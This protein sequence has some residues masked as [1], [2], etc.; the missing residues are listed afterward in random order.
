MT[1]DELIK[2]VDE[3][4]L[5]AID[6]FQSSLSKI[7]EDIFS[8]VVSEITQL[9]TSQGNITV[10]IENL[11]KIDRI[12]S[13]INE[14]VLN[15]DYIN[16]V[17]EFAKTFNDVQGILNTYFSS[18]SAEFGVKSVY[19]AVRVANIQTTIESLVGAGI[20]QGLTNPIKN[21][22]ND[23]VVN[24][25]TQKSLIDAMK[26]Q[27][28]SKPNELAGL[29]KYAYQIT[30]D[31]LYQ[32]Q[33]NYI[34][35]VSNDLGLDWFLYQGSEQNTSR[36]FCVER[37]GGYFAKKEIEYWGKTPSLW[38]NCKTKKH[39]GGGRITETNEKTIFQY[40]GGWNCKHMII[41]VSKLAV[42]KSAIKRATD[43]GFNS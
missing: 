19:D 6:N 31:A 43:L 18:L 5:N 9:K 41:P 8:E 22:L 13:K 30:N 7:N 26:T 16:S 10:S 42:P 21:I 35:T 14:I 36:C 40:R 34:N 37:K 4:I 24:G 20:E 3:T 39:K 32:F 25:A 29:E 23:Y 15:K 28:L 33:G 1:T 27:I 17:T 2:Q 11:K 12:N 38:N